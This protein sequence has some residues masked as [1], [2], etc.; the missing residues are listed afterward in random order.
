MNGEKMWRARGGLA[1]W[2]LV[3]LLAPA[4]V[5]GQGA[6]LPREERV[7]RLDLTLDYSAL[8]KAPSANQ[9]FQDSGD[10]DYTKGYADLSGKAGAFEIA[11]IILKR[12]QDGLA[13]ETDLAIPFGIE[14]KR[15]F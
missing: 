14:W 15:R 10:P 13:S 9:G 2:G 3:V 12:R 1:L 5:Y 11:P 6:D 4:T 7:P 8:D